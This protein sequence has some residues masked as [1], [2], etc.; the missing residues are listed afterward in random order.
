MDNIFKIRL[1]LTNTFLLRVSDGYLLVDVGTK[2]R[3]KKLLRILDDYNITPNQIKYIVS[4]HA[5]YDHV[6]G[7]AE[8]KEITGAKVIAHR[9]AK[10]SLE[11][12]RNSY[13]GLRIKW[14]NPIIRKILERVHAFKPVTPDIIIDDK[15]FFDEYG[16][17]L[18]I[19]H[20]PGHTLCS[21]SMIDE[22]GNAFV[23]D[24][25]IR[26]PFKPL[27]GFSVIAADFK[28][29]VP[30]WKKIIEEGAKRVY[31]A[32]GKSL[33]IE[34]MIRKTKRKK[35]KSSTHKA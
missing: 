29:L 4:T 21:I 10:E 25:A 26:Y 28:L 18:R 31:I 20:T 34:R 11:Q 5:H 22:D 8:I 16:T 9:N 12:G 33:K 15:Y 35:W 6:G 7:L 23:G 32:H 27:G 13:V 30:S 17:D 14:F 1:G 3:T 19:I 24:T 2:R